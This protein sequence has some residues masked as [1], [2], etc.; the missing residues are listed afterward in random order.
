MIGKE[1]TSSLNHEGS[2][3]SI[4]SF[5]TYLADRKL[6]YINLVGDADSKTLTEV[7]TVIHMEGKKSLNLNV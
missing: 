1:Q 5:G 7:K 6:R 3:G 2:P 4:G